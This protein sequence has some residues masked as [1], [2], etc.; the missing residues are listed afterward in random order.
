MAQEVI[1]EDRK[2]ILWF[3]ISF[4]RYQIANGRIY[5]RHG[6]IRQ[7]EH[8]CLIYR[9]LDISLERTLL[10][11]ICGTGTIIMRTRDASDAVLVLRNIKNS[12]Q[13]KDM[14]SE[15]IEQEKE[16]KGI[17]GRDMY[18]SSRGPANQY[19]DELTDED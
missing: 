5:C 11:R 4:D 6:L 17:V 12:Q 16:A 8:E 1:W 9:I 14:L 10:N 3:G 13:V 19:Y 7:Q 15:M 18:G 2:H